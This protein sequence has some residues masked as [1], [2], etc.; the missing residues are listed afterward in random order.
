ME[1][2]NTNLLLCWPTI[3]FRLRYCSTVTAC[4]KKKVSI[5]T[6]S[7][8]W[9][10]IF[11]I[12]SSFREAFNFKTEHVRRSLLIISNRKIRFVTKLT[13]QILASFPC[14]I[15]IKYS[16][17]AL[18]LHN[19]NYVYWHEWPIYHTASL[20]PHRNRIISLITRS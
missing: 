19:L 4:Q 10:F 14:L 17:N 12:C 16:Y 11:G 5:K 20:L 8:Q 9:K 18:K 6:L 2:G 1:I 15:R 3:W 13:L 7:K